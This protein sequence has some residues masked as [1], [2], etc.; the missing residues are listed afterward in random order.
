[1]MVFQVPGDRVRP[2][3]QALPRQLLA[4]LDDQPGAGRAFWAEELPVP[5]AQPQLGADRVNVQERSC[6]GPDV[7][8]RRRAATSRYCL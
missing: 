6:S 3:I 5:A 1:V 8:G 2:G 7:A 4:Q